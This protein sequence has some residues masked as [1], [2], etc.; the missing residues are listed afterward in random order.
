VGSVN[1][2]SCIAGEAQAPALGSRPGSHRRGDQEALGGC[3]GRQSHTSSETERVKDAGEASAE[4]ERHQLAPTLGR[5]AR[6]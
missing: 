3:T 6:C 2:A 5:A 4:K 1:K